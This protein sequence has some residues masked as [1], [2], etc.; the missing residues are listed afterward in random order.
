MKLQSVI[1]D[2]FFSPMVLEEDF[3][4]ITVS[5]PSMER[6]VDESGKSKKVRISVAPVLHFLTCGANT[7][8]VSVVSYSPFRMLK[9]DVR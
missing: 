1:T 3:P 8:E 6:E 2:G 9:C 5:I 7:P 4:M